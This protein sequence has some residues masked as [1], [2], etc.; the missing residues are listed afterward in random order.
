[1]Q[2][3]KHAFLGRGPVRVRCPECLVARGR[4][5]AQAGRDL[6]AV[7]GRDRLELYCRACGEFLLAVELRPVPTGEF[8]PL[9]PEGLPAGERG[10]RGN[11]CTGS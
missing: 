3:L 9:Y 5:D 6:R 8:L 1:M 2:F 7:I 10:E 11:V 4:Q